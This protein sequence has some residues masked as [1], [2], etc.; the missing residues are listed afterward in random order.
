MDESVKC[1]LSALVGAAAAFLWVLRGKVAE[2][3]KQPPVYMKCRD[4]G[5][6]H[7]VYPTGK[8]HAL[9]PDARQPK[10]VPPKTWPPQGTELSCLHMQ[11]IGAEGKEVCNRCG[12][13]MEQYAPRM[14]RPKTSKAL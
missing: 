13:E 5:L 2:R 10:G 4:C 1:L 3:A 11:V 8:V 12:V 6:E 9:R 14:W 7:A